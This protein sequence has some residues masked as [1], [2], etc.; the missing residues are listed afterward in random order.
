GERKLGTDMKYV[1]WLILAVSFL[2]GTTVHADSKFAAISPQP[3]MSALDEFVAHTGLQV[4]YRADVASGI[5][6]KGADSGLTP[7]HALEQ[8]LRDTGLRYEFI[9][10]RT[11]AIRSSKTVAD[12]PVTDANRPAQE[13]VLLAQNPSSSPASNSTAETGEEQIREIVVTAQK[14]SE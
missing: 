4:I 2:A 10:D 8:L 12:R 11:V 5:Q 7:L 3:L 1:S 13:S 6:S 9:N 14:K